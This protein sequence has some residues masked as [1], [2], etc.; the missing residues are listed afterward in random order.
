MA[1]R[2]TRHSVPVLGNAIKNK[3]AENIFWID[4]PAKTIY[5]NVTRQAKTFNSKNQ[6]R[7]ESRKMQIENGCFL[8]HKKK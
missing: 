3:S 5:N 7:R 1:K 2:K 4:L 8:V 6:V